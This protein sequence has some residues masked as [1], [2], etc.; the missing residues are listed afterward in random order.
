MFIWQ[1]EKMLYKINRTR[2][3][4]Y[5]LC[6]LLYNVFTV[7]FAW[8][9]MRITDSLVE[10]DKVI[11][12]SYLGIAGAGIGFQLLFHFLS[13]R[14]QNKIISVSMNMIRSKS[15]YGILKI[16][17][18]YLNE[19]KKKK[20]VS[21]FSSELE[22]FENSYLRMCLNLINSTM[23]LILSGGMIFQIHRIMLLIVILMMLVMVLI[24]FLLAGGLQKANNNYLDSNKNLIHKTEEYLSGYEVIKSFFIENKIFHLY[25][26][27]V[28][29]C[30]NDKRK[31]ENKMGISNAISGIMSILII[32]T[33]FIAGGYLILKSVITVG[34]LLAIVQLIS[35]MAAP[36]T[37]ILY[38]INEI[39]SVK[40]IKRKVIEL[41]EKANEIGDN[42]SLLP[43]G[44]KLEIINL[45]YSYKN[46]EEP[47]LKNV[48]V[49]ME[50]GKTYAVV[51]E[52]GCGKSTLAKIVAGYYSDYSGAI[53]ID[54]IDF[55]SIPSY[56]IRERIVYMNQKEFLFNASFRDNCT[57]FDTYEINHE[58]LCSMESNELF[59]K[60]YSASMMSGGERQKIAFIRSFNKSSDILIC[61]EAESAMDIFSRKQ[62]IRL[63]KA[64]TEKIKVVITHTI[65]DSLRDYDRILYLKNG[66]L[67]EKG[68]F[69]ELYHTKG[70]FYTYYN[71]KYDL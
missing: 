24:P 63:L 48:E 17:G 22:F 46:Q 62:F 43:L 30:C 16:D 14:L 21:Y 28:R 68:S 2:M 70:E 3:V 47:V 66:T 51:G 6:Q 57:L 32:L 12:V 26:E 40:E 67:K 69:D 55:K 1:G 36:L 64:D 7:F 61:D 20:Y 49:T 15:L 59:Q 27:V 54:G 58:L 52:N 45:S 4:I 65:D 33:T 42:P 13:F 60:E 38:G 10:G 39:N 50:Q 29:K 5:G 31:L 35:N 18:R 44:T 71:R 11:F 56:R 23:L 19:D 34:A 9:I 25:E 37:D 8:V 41:L 53:R